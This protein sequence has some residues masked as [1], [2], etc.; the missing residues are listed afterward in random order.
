[1]RKKRLPKFERTVKKAVDKSERIIKK[2]KKKK[3]LGDY[4]F[5]DHPLI[6]GKWD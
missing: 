4:D 2:A 3:I 5:S 1:M 6:T